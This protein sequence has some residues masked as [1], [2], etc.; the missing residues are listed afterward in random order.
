MA[1]NQA[2]LPMPP[3]ENPPQTRSKRDI[4]RE[5]VSKKYPDR[6]FDNE[7]D[8]YDQIN[9]DYDE[10]EKQLESYRSN[11]SKLSDM[12]TAD[13]RSGSFLMEWMDGANPVLALVNKYGTEFV[14]YMNDPEH[15][16]EVA[17]AQK[18]Y[19]ERVSKEKEL[20]DT[21]KKN[22]DAS[23]D[24]LEQTQA[25]NGWTDEQVDAAMQK[26]FS[27]VND[28]ILGK[29]TT[30]TI[31][32][33]MNGENFDQAVAI[34]DEEGELRGRNAKIEE[35]MRK[36][37]ASDGTVHLDGKNGQT[38]RKLSQRGIFELAGEAQ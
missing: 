6:N 33:V 12:M 9:T 8:L 37:K 23:I 22:L 5:R 34:A 25:E 18:E 28:A 30:E 1:E 20:E 24:T 31:Q 29:F 36:G 35:K 2:P 3:E 13:P 32:L 10:S 16:E 19:L 27:I 14:E 4:L 26:L 7:D 15:Q 21:Y 11:E 38:T 17:K